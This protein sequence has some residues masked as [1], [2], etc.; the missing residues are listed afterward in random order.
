MGITWQYDFDDE[1]GEPFAKYPLFYLLMK[2]GIGFDRVH[3]GARWMEGCRLTVEYK[4][5]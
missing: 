3:L 1:N 2:L 4:T 5:K